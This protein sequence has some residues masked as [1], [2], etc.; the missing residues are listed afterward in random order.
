MDAGR[1]LKPATDAVL[2]DGRAPYQD[3]GAILKLP[4]EADEGSRYSVVPK[5]D[6]SRSRYI[7]SVVLSLAVLMTLL[8]VFVG[9]VVIET[10]VLDEMGSTTKA[11]EKVAKYQ[12][13]KAFIG[14]AVGLIIE[15]YFAVFANVTTTFLKN[16]PWYPGD[17]PR[18]HASSGFKRFFF[19]VFSPFVVGML[20]VSIAG[21]FVS[22]Q[23]TGVVR[24]FAHDD[25]ATTKA[26]AMATLNAT[27]AAN[28]T[29]LGN[30]RSVLDTILRGAVRHQVVP[31]EMLTDS[32]C[33]LGNGTTGDYSGAVLPSVKEVRST[34][35][36]Y[37]FPLQ[38]WNLDAMPFGLVPDHTVEFKLSE[39]NG[40]QSE[41]TRKFE[42]FQ[43]ASKMSW[44]TAYEMLL[45]GKLLFERSI[46]DSN[47]SAEY[48]CI[49]VEDPDK[50]Y[51]IMETVLLGA[52]KKANVTTNSSTPAPTTKKPMARNRSLQ[53]S[54]TGNAG[55]NESLSDLL[56][57]EFDLFTDGPFKGERKCYGAVS[58][59]GQFTN[60]TDPSMH[61]VDA[62]LNTTIESFFDTVPQVEPQSMTL[63]VSAYTISPQIK[64]TT[65]ALDM[66]Y[67]ESTEYRKT[68]DMCD[69]D[70]LRPETLKLLKES[71]GSEPTK[72]AITEATRLLCDQRSYPYLTPREACGHS[73]CV[74][75]DKS[76]TIPFKKQ[77]QLIPY[78][79]NCSTTDR[80]YDADFLNFFPSGCKPQSDAVFLYG[81]GSYMTGKSFES[82]DKDSIPFI[83]NPRRHV[84]LSFARL[85]W[86][87]DDLSA[88]FQA[89][90]RA[91]A[92]NCKGLLFNLENVTL[93]ALNLTGRNEKHVRMLVLG[94]DQLPAERMDKDFRNPVQLV[95]LNTRPFYYAK[96]KAY[97]EWEYIDKSRFEV[98][99][100]N[101]ATDGK[102]GGLS[103]DACSPLVDSYITQVEQNHFYIDDPLQPLYTSALYY[104]FQDAAVKSV[105]VTKDVT[106][107]MDALELSVVG[108][109]QLKGDLVKHVIKY[110][111]PLASMLSTFG[112]I[113]LVLF[114]AMLVLVRPTER[115]KMS[116]K[117]NVA[118]RYAEL[119]QNDL[120]PGKVFERTLLLPSGDR[121]QMDEY[122]VESATV[123]FTRDE[124][125]KVFL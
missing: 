50:Y 25:L 122:V 55:A 41:L 36:V 92:G 1:L 86:Q 19:R 26:F 18:A 103:G 38:D 114:I 99:T 119:L 83:D 107:G 80:Q 44:T 11:N 48:P 16:V 33:V 124:D 37:G 94:N 88:K 104:L 30:K 74:F 51:R 115:L 9:G 100:K 63:T 35:V 43:T 105:K 90:C 54:A 14:A 85:E 108:T 73:S 112:G 84:V 46:S 13:A 95:S 68:A 22:H 117:T 71:L 64:L 65:M 70:T 106:T 89:E 52:T 6:L 102:K 61:T 8:W 60:M 78:L 87:T 45:Q 17:E 120:Y 31:F 12:V 42:A 29:S 113:F 91:N 81:L 39:V 32:P 3:E 34:A 62:F 7:T 77:L 111:I 20:N 59:L 58:S 21:M 28:L 4:A 82:G 98:A 40:T 72:E 76:G 125:K 69:G 93:P 10:A 121:V 97:Y 53:V 101:N 27:T 47:V 2:Q 96:E 49:Q 110:S 24:V 67:F 118:V 109:T 75:L 23:T 116:E 123:H 5:L 57:T 15:S 66:P 79:T 56:A